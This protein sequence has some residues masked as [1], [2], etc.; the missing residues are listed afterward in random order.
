MVS[1][2]FLQSTTFD[3]QCRE[4]LPHILTHHNVEFHHLI[5]VVSVDKI[6][7]DVEMR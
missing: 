3:T 6:N 7:W 2:K 5:D 1:K 4:V